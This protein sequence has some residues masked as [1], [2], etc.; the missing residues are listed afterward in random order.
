MT[1]HRREWGICNDAV[2]ADLSS[3]RTC[4]KVKVFFH[5]PLRSKSIGSHL[6]TKGRPA[7]RSSVIAF[8]LLSASLSAIAQAAPDEGRYTVHML[9]HAIGSEQYSLTQNGDRL[10]LSTTATYSDRGMKH[11][12]TAMLQMAPDYTPRSF[13]QKSGA[14]SPASTVQIEKNQ[15]TIHEANG[16]RTIPMP[17]KAFVGFGTLPATVQMAMIRYWKAQHQPGHLPILRASDHAL[18]AEIKLAGHDTLKLTTN[19]VQLTRYTV[20]NLM[21]GRE[22]L[23]LDAQDHLAAVMTF[24]GGLPIEVIRD[25]YEPALQQLVHAGVQQEMAD[26]DDLARAV[27]PI[28]TG[29][30]A[31]VGAALIN[32][33]GEQ[34]IP[35]ATVLIRDGRIAAA[36]SSTTVKLPANTRIIHAEGKSLLPGLW[37]MHAHYSGVEFGPALLAQG[38][39]TARDCGGEFEFL[40]TVRHKIDAEHGL[41]PHLLLAGLIDGPGIDGFG[42]TSIH[43]PT[44]AQSIVDRYHA[45][46]FE[47]IK[48]YTLLKPDEIKALAD[49][50]HRD[51]M[52]VTGHV[53]AA[54]NAFAGVELGMDQIN[55]LQFVTRAMNPENS[56]Q[57]ADLN[58]DRAKKL[59]ELLASH[60]IVVDPTDSWGEMAGHAK[61]IPVSS[62]EP[63]ITT[64]PYTLSS[65]YLALGVPANSDAAKLYVQRMETNRNVVAA[66]H[67][68]GVQLVAGSD[69]GLLGY[70]LDRELEL[71][72]QSGMTPIEVI[73]IATIG[74][75]RIMHLD[76]ETGSIAPGKRADLILIDGNPLANISD[77]RKV[78]QVVTQGR[79]YDSLAL[80]RSVGFNVEN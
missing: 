27:P 28:A 30:F 9:L 62:F 74:A 29:T 42:D 76:K 38:I 69:T 6:H 79:I 67:Q 43:T 14:T 65:K 19:S 39:T 73:Q 71:Y 55:H 37:E 53:P 22:V 4:L 63:G 78:S 46:G 26:L 31:I 44:E 24:A 8:L 35:N 61:D 45:A 20:A 36:G 10:T 80:H 12:T 7:M 15:A 32:T 51:G 58:S 68:A 66:L 54:V 56:N 13:E 60:H 2:R 25:E 59:I 5:H 64:A 21:F 52:T 3:E 40:T 11:S 47:Q 48:L 18:P 33:T 17:A 23:W 16:E 72:T 34:P 77:I 1:A 57:T 70:G 50:A 75:A 49:A 41:G